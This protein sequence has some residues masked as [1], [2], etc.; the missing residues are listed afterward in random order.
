V[1]SL[2]TTSALSGTAAFSH[3]DNFVNGQPCRR[4]EGSYSCVLEGLVVWL[5]KYQCAT[6]TQ[7]ITAPFA[8]A[9]YTVLGR[10][11]HTY[12]HHSSTSL[13]VTESRP[14]LS[15]HTGQSTSALSKPLSLSDTTIVTKSVFIKVHPPRRCARQRPTSTITNTGSSLA[16]G[17]LAIL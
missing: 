8:R 7:S 5:I 13:T 6:A 10:Q 14:T 2:T 11:F 15:I 17:L 12:S 3:C 16:S 1:F 9:P 4:S